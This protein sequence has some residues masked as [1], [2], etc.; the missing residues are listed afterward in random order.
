MAAGRIAMRILPPQ[1]ET[2]VGFLRLD[3]MLAAVVRGP[4]LRRGAR[5][6]R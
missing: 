6:G 5:E 4:V 1:A 2:V 3:L